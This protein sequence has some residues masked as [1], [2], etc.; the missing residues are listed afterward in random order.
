VP[1]PPWVVAYHCPCL[2]VAHSVAVDDVVGVTVLSLS[3]RVK[4]SL[5]NRRS[6]LVE[7]C[8]AAPP[9]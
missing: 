1:A 2:R 3:A 8:P 7:R 6:Y 9:A 5:P 4:D